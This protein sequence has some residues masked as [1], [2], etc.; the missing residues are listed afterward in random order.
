MHSRPPPNQQE[1]P[2]PRHKTAADGT[3]ERG[4][5]RRKGEPSMPK[6][7]SHSPSP[8]PLQQLERTEQERLSFWL[9]PW[10]L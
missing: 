1:T 9:F 8:P 6:G 5:E 10:G 3:E 7:R 4:R 2:S